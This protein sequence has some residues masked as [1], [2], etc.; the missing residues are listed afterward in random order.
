MN[1][2]LDSVFHSESVQA[3]AISNLFILV[4]IVCAVILLIVT[5]MVVY[6]LVRFRRKPG[7]MEPE[8]RHGNWKLETT[9][10]VV[11]FLLLL[12]LLTLTAKGMKGSDP[13]LDQKPDLL[14][15]SHQWWWEA[16]YPESGVVTANEIHIPVGIRWLVRLESADVIHDFWVPRLAPKMDVVPGHPNRLWLE[17]DK[18][19]AYLGTC[20]EFCGA[21]HAQMHFLVIA[22]DAAEFGAWQD[23]QGKPVP[24]K[25]AEP[26][27]EGSR[28]FQQMTCVNCHTINGTQAKGQTAPDLSHFGGRQTLGAVLLPNTPENLSRWLKN[29]QEVKPAV[30]MPDL[31]LTD[32]QVSAL[33]A[34]LE[35]LQ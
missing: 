35:S 15:I 13:P 8:P 1:D 23:K 6:S 10:T 22:Q 12:W 21:Q 27:Q 32:V 24:P 25:L 14:V 31:K 16:R 18:P 28:I 2:A 30:L 20:S 9:W 4:L 34:Y 29:P 33:T 11:P 26:A 3:A 19:G 5:A 17:A 7:G